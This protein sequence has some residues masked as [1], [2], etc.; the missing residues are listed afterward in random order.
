ML[1]GQAPR[2]VRRAHWPVDHVLLSHALPPLPSIIRGEQREP[3]FSTDTPLWSNLSHS[4]DDIT[5]LLGDEGEIGHDIEIVYPHDNWQ[6]LA[7]TVSSLG[8]HTKV[9]TKRP[10]QQLA[11][12]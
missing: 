9:E 6:A 1:S 4:G 12:L 3:A 8:E 5:L 2:G 7:D 10:E 11:T